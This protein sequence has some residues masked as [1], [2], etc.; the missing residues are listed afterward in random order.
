MAEVFLARQVGAVGIGRNVVI[1][2]VLPDLN[3]NPDFLKL[4]IGEAQLSMQLSHG[5]VVQVFDFGEVD[6]QYFLAMEWVD[7]LSLRQ[8]IDFARA[9]GADAIPAPIAVVIVIELCKALQYAHT[10]ANEDGESLKVVHRDVSPENVLLSWE[11]QVKLADFGIARAAMVGR[12]RTNPNVFRGRFDFAAPE[13]ARG[14]AVDG[15]SDL[16]SVGVLL[17]EMVLGENPILARAYEIASGQERAPRFPP[18][19]VDAGLAAI[20]DKCTEPLAVNRY[21]SAQELQRALQGWLTKNAQVVA[22]TALPNFLGWVRPEEVKRRGL[23]AEVTQDFTEWL[24]LWRLKPWTQPPNEQLLVSGKKAAITAK[25]PPRKGSRALVGLIVASVVMAGALVVVVVSQDEPPPG[26]AS[27]VKVVRVTPPPLPPPEPPLNPTG[28]PERPRTPQV[29]FG[30]G[31]VTINSKQHQRIITAESGVALSRPTEKWVVSAD[32]LSVRRISK[33]GRPEFGELFLFAT[34]FDS[35]GNALES[36]TISKRP[37][38][39][40]QSATTAQIWIIE[41]VLLNR[42]T[43]A[44]LDMKVLSGSEILKDIRRE[45]QLSIASDQRYS[46]SE[47]D[48]AERYTVEASGTADVLAVLPYSEAKVARFESKEQSFPKDQ[49]LLPRQGSLKFS[50]SS[51]L[52]VSIVQS[53]H[54][55]E[56]EAVIRVALARG[57]EPP[58]IVLVKRARHSV[59][60]KTTSGLAIGAAAAALAKDCQARFPNSCAC[61]LGI[62]DLYSRAGPDHF[63]KAQVAYSRFLVCAPLEDPD[64]PRVGKW[65]ERN[66]RWFPQSP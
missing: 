33:S 62:G 57:D 43:K 31:T 64:R 1:K 15:R 27:P 3:D 46:F 41:S 55:E 12:E 44:A 28:V 5:N 49:A 42:E 47:L 16:Y 51:E 54:A 25:L 66:P 14:Q 19:A 9:Q 60:S 11:G 2:R 65:V 48:P 20:V 39:A 21:Q 37:T 10:R 32:Y 50:G 53:E 17:T 6:G 4:F 36:R 7:G 22:V 40:P 30:P 38:L 45:V 58:D 26:K 24:E 23:P 13:Q 59:E 52:W 63:T 34:F 8:L 18:S 56:R 61:Q 35:S 29:H